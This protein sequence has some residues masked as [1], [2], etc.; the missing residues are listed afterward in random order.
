MVLTCVTIRRACGTLLVTFTENQN[1]GGLCSTAAE[2]E[3]RS[4]G[5]ADRAKITSYDEV[6]DYL[7]N[8]T[9]PEGP[10]KSVED[11][12]RKRAKSSNSLYG[13]LHYKEILKTAQ[14][15]VKQVTYCPKYL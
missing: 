10:T 7:A 14:L 2:I 6:Q 13:V 8:D 5:E 15:R 1:Y 9:Y 4:G 3:S 11:V 12:I